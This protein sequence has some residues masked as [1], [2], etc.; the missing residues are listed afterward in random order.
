MGAIA[1]NAHFTLLY[2]DSGL[3]NACLLL[4]LYTQ[5]HEEWRA[6]H[7]ASKGAGA[8]RMKDVSDSDQQVDINVTWEQLHPEWKK[9]NLE[10]GRA[11]V[12]AVHQHLK[13]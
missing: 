2:K 6:T 13:A 3:S 9:E 10:A 4:P 5:A 7:E 11:A 1:E 12:A 8:P